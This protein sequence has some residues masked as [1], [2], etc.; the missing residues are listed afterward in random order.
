MR[1][2]ISCNN[3]ITY[4]LSKW[5]ASVLSS[6]LGAI[7]D[8][9]IKRNTEFIDRIK[10]IN[11]TDCNMVSFDVVSL[12]TRVPIEQFLDFSSGFLGDNVSGLPK[13]QFRLLLDLCLRNNYF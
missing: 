11:M 4:K 9:H 13:S 7:S 1:P 5:L 12:F 6:C 3:S 2:I 10:N 8:S